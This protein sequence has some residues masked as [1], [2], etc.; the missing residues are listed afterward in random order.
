MNEKE[1]KCVGSGR[2]RRRDRNKLVSSVSRKSNVMVND[3]KVI[4]TKTN[5]FM[6]HKSSFY[7]FR[8]LYIMS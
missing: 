2:E 3:I 5:I 4:R 7:S 6:L 1:R 8:F